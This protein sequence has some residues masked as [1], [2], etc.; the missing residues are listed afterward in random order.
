MFDRRPARPTRRNR[1]ARPRRLCC[2]DQWRYLSPYFEQLE[3]RCLLATITWNG[4]G[5]GTTWT[6][7][8]NWI[9]G[10]M[11]GPSDEAVIGSSSQ[12]INVSGSITVGSVVSGAPLD[13]TSGSLTVESGTSQANNGLTVSSGASLIATGTGTTWNASGTTVIGGASIH[14]QS[15]A[16]LSLPSVTTFSSTSGYYTTNLQATGTGSTLSLPNLSS[17]GTINDWLYIQ[18][19]QG[20]QTELPELATVAAPSNFVELDAEN[21]G[22]QLD[23]PIL[24]SFQPGNSGSLIDLT[25]ATIFDPDLTSLN[26]VSATLDGSGTLAYS[27][28]TT[29]TGAGNG[30]TVTGGSYSFSDLTDLD[31]TSLYAQGG[32]SI[33]LPVLASFSSTSG[34]YVPSFQAT[35]TGSTLNLSDLSSLG[36]INNTFYIQALQGGQTELPELATVAAPSNFVELDAEN[37]GSQ[38]DVP[39]LSS[40]QPGNS[41]SL[42][43]LTGATIFDPDLTSLNNVSATLDG[44]GTLAYSQWTTFTGAGNGITVTGGSYS[45]SD[46][47]DLDGTSLYA[48]GGGSIA[49]P[50][51]ASFSSTSGYYVPSFQATGTGSTLSLSDLSSL[52]TLNSTLHIQ[53][54]QGGQTELP[55]LATVAAPSN[56][57]ELDAENAGSQLDVPILSSFQP[58]NSGSLIDL[59]GAT[60]VDPDLTSLNNVSA[61]LDG[62]GTL[63]YSQW[64]TFTGAGNGITVTGGSYSF[65]DLTDLD[66]T[67][68]YAQGGGSIALPVLASFSSTSGYYVPSFQATGTGSTLSLS[69]LS[70][71]GTL[72][73]T[74]HIQALQGGQTEL[75]ELATVAAPSN[76]LELDAENAGSQLDVPILSSF[77]PGNSGSLI[78][79]TGATIVDPDL[80]S[81]N[82]VSATLDGSGT[83]AYSQW[84]TFTGAG[85]GITVTGGSY[86][87]SDLTDLDGTSLYAQGGGSIAL[88][89]LASFSSTSGY[90]VPSFQATGTGST[91]SLSDLSSLGTLN[92]TLHIQALQGGQTELP[93]LAT[94][95]APSN[96]LELDAENA[97]S[98]LDVPI[99][100]SF[101]P[102]NSGSL[103]DLT[104]ATIVDPDLT[105]LNNVSATLDGSGT[106]AY[107][108][109]TTFTGAGNGIT[110]TGGSYSFSDLTDLDGTSLYAQG[111]G[112]IALPVLASFSSTSGYYVPSFQA[113]GTGSTL[114]LSD[115]SSLGTLNS[116]LHIQ[117]L[118]GGQTELPELATVAAPSNY[119]ELDAENAGSQLD[120]PILS[121]FQP[122]N[123]GSL[124]DLTGATIV[125][126]DLTSLNNVSATLDGS[127]TLAYSQWTTF[128]GA[129]NGITVTGGSYSFSDLTNL[130]GTSLYA[131]GGGSIALP[132]LASF[133][134]TSTYY[135][136]SFQATG[137]GST[138][139]LSDL[140]SLGTLNST[141]HIQAL[142][143]GQTELPELATV[144]APS[145]F[146][147]L[148]AENAGSQ[149][150][151]PI[152]TSFQP[153]I[154]GSIL[155]LT[156]G[157][158][159]DPELIYITN[160]NLTGNSTGTIS[161]ASNQVYA[162]TIGTSTVQGGTLIDQGSVSAQN[163]ATIDIPGSLTV[164]GEGT[165]STTS[166]A[167]VQIGGN[168]LGNTLNA[169][170]FNP[171][172]TVLFNSSTSSASSP[173]L[174]EAM[175][176]DLGPEAAGFQNNFD[177]GTISLTNNTYVQL[178][179]QTHNSSGT[180]AETV[181]ADSIVVPAGTTL[182]LNGLNLYTHSEQ[183][184]GTVLIGT[185]QVVPLGAG[186][187]TQV[188]VT[189]QPPSSVTA[190]AGFALTVAVE[191]VYD[192]VVTS[193]T[194]NVTVALDNNP[195]S[196]S[197]GGT[198]TVSATS[199]VAT[200]SGLTLNKV[201]SGYTLAATSDTLTSATS[202]AISVTPGTATQLVITTQPASYVTAGAGFG[203]AVTAEDSDG[204]VDTGFSGTETV[205]IADNPGGSSLGGTLT[206]SA[207]S[208]VASFSGLTLDK[209]ASGYALS[210]ASGT[211]TSATSSAISVASGTIC[212]TAHHQPATGHRHR[213]QR[214]RIH[215]HGRRQPRQRDHQLHGQ[216]Y[217]CP[218]RQ[219]RWQCAGWHAHGKCHQRRGQ[220]L[221][222]DA[223]QDWQRL[224][225]GRDQRHADVRDQ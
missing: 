193:F 38:L 35:G 13:I 73:S 167:T 120:V 2:F 218:A 131:Q 192:E 194:G 54:L 191:D 89:V 5:D 71:L 211:L 91:L 189:T 88:P 158:I 221:R 53:A 129:G 171:A 49:L 111:G 133:S 66:G 209:A 127:G 178:V 58:G 34:Y 144:A 165:L 96:Y 145:N 100:S 40:F 76:Y 11:P 168:L 124:I 94:V 152:L 187:P 140:S 115:L 1:T 31:G 22:S 225:I 113:T 200:F 30:I 142:Q 56:Y 44:S 3:D 123:S 117:A 149:L 162:A 62:S 92:S 196:S 202:N 82:N 39:I 176:A 93:E 26:N 75:P 72:N 10:V 27:Q 128:T 215:G 41:G 182:D 199:G 134:S 185:I 99:L 7:P 97:G 138:L 186:V 159:V 47:T 160:V 188:V 55:E 64:T 146:V 43:D 63:A 155:E 33:A 83:L 207:T 102:G 118:Q 166:N 8:A 151:V 108:Q 223:Q 126:P 161:I 69:D 217:R 85:N 164:S 20:G 163:N 114:S 205:A 110:V 170:G 57:L 21:A 156:G 46:L 107:S 195:G 203:F 184:N 174:L 80:T 19:L 210:V 181:Y 177:Y 67:S 112:S 29:F 36:T 212:A 173:Q 150:D 157:T 116:T 101:Q 95:A 87:F 52:G 6:N 147:E 208:G 37:A 220:F 9:G 183:I 15:G 219:P 154:S 190:G 65:S 79:L 139:S 141:L 197:L 61:T 48:Q 14:A 50:V 81:L 51:L 45:F 74:L 224:Y 68:L 103:I 214:V 201:G 109:W 121:S 4:S 169:D 153:G 122:G 106:L 148:D 59:T 25:G 23:V 213:G 119:L 125:D 180:G 86:S 172:G 175:S 137:T 98:Q 17:L 136:P 32:G 204:N 42:I 206:A 216:H 198:L 77:Q 179:D 104:G 135:N 222:P 132:V 28:W 143:G 90:Y 78:D 105:S 18:A 24:S 60:I 12:T 130:D 84:T 70:S 16:S